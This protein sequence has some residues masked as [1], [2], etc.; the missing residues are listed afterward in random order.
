VYPIFTRYQH[1]LIL[2]FAQCRSI[3]LVLDMITA[4]P[5]TAL[6]QQV[7]NLATRMPTISYLHEELFGQAF[8]SL[9]PTALAERIHA[10]MLCRRTSLMFLLH[11]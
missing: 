10:T 7:I 4:P 6:T 5:C 11:D 1:P 3:L 9:R 2:D 8:S